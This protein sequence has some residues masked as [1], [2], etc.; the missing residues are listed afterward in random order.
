VR[1]TLA[2]SI[3]LVVVLAAVVYLLYRYS[4]LKVWH[5]LVCVLFGFYL[6]A[7]SMAPEIRTTVT[8]IVHALT[9]RG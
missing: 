4:G 2:I 5:A 9:G 6:A 1:R 7:T 8:A 3:S